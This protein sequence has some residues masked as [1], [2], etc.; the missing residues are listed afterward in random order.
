MLERTKLSIKFVLGVF[1]EYG[2]DQ[3]EYCC[4]DLISKKC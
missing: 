2:L 1:L 4:F 3:K